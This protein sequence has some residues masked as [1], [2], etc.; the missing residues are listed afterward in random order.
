M[1]SAELLRALL[2]ANFLALLPR[3]CGSNP[4]YTV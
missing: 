1:I 4:H 2:L 3:A